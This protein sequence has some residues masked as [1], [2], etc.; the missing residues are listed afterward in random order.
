MQQ[1]STFLHTT[2]FMYVQIYRYTYIKIYI[3]PA[4]N[5]HMVQLKTLFYIPAATSLK[6]KR[7]RY[8]KDKGRDK[9]QRRQVDKL[10]NHKT[11]TSR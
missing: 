10:Q 3:Q 5:I 7:K 1:A 8:N 11:E 9:N 4:I 6:G 2:V